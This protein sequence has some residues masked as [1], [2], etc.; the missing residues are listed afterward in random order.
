[1]SALVYFN[2]GIGSLTGQPLFFYLKETLGLSPSTVMYLGSVTTLPWMIKPL[3]GWL[4]D[5]FPVWGYR[6]KSYMILSGLLGVCTALTIGII[7]SLPLFALYAFLILDALSGAMKDVAVD[8]I[9]VE[10]G[11]RHEITG[12][13]Q[14]IQWGSLTLA[15]VITGI[16]GGWIAEH[17]D[18]HLSFLIVALFPAAV[19][20]L[21]CLYKEQP[22][23]GAKSPVSLREVLKNKRLLLSMLFLFLFWFSPAFGAPVLFKMRDE[24]HFS[25][26]TMGLLSTVGSACSI[27]GA[28]WYWRVNR[29][30][31]IKKWLI[32]SVLVSGFS[33]FAYLYLT[34]TSIWVYTVLFGI[35]S[36]AIQLIVMDFSARICP[37]G[38]EAT[39]FALITSILNLGTFLSGMAGGKLY[40]LVGYNWLVIISGAATFLC[41][42]LIPTLRV[43]QAD[44]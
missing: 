28:V 44:A 1:M 10:E 41:L 2:Q 29:T 21:A 42:P 8:G 20:C 38:K 7:P 31:N 6:R 11:Q 12:K 22:A 36:M 13:I 33:T 39:T 43:E 14:S 16:A 30:L 26:F 27:L 34:P 32:I 17:F 25:R 5:T 19:A 40:E 37:K 15:T 24:F 4:S 3:Y 35:F 9:M 18:Y 23:P